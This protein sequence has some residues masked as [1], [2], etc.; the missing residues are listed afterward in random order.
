MRSPFE[1]L[2]IETKSNDSEQ[3]ELEEHEDSEIVDKVETPS[4]QMFEERPETHRPQLIG[5]SADPA[6]MADR[7]K[8]KKENGEK[9]RMSPQQEVVW[10]KRMLEDRSV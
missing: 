7:L 8:I 2:P 9:Y 6:A 1:G 10:L 5:A 4:A 3:E